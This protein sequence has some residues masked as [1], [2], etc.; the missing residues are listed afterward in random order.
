MPSA[1]QTK[2]MPDHQKSKNRNSDRKPSGNEQATVDDFEEEGMGVA[3][4]E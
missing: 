1:D 3:P 4:K 2:T